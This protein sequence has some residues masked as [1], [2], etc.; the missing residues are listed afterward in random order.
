MAALFAETSAR[1]DRLD[2]AGVLLHPWADSRPP[3][4]I[5]S[6]QGL[7]VRD[8][9]G[10]ELM[11]FT[12]GYFVNQAGHGPPA[13]IEA[14]MRQLGAV[15]QVS[16]RTPTPASM[17]LA[18]A[19]VRRAPG[20]LARVLYTT[21]GSES[22]EAAI[23]MARQKTGKPGVAYLDNAFH[24]LGATALSACGLDRYRET[25]GGPLDPTFV[26][27]P[28]PHA[29]RCPEPDSCAR[30]RLAAIEAVLDRSPQVGTLLAEPIQAVGCIAPS[31]AW[32]ARLDALRRARGLLLVLDEI[33]TGL[34][35]TGRFF[36]AE[37]YGLEPDVLLVAKGLSGG[38]GSL[39]AVVATEE[40]AGDFRMATCATS[41]GNAVSCAA[42]LALVELV[43]RESL[44]SRA[45]A[46][47]RRIACAIESWALP[48]VHEVR[49]VG[50]L[51]GVDL[52]I[53]G[54][55]PM[56]RITDE[57]LARGILISGRGTFLRIQ[58]PL[59]IEPDAIDLFL[60]RLQTVLRIA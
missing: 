25:A 26:R 54:L 6:A 59:N 2:P 41:A 16:P 21:G 46:A 1:D 14:A 15:S 30:T 57:L 5:V 44:A 48:A 4:Q 33:H 58:P 38:V 37:H 29:C 31:R 12:S 11:D 39:G 43:E 53:E 32:W 23:R 42:G 55:D 22:V 60:D 19:L 34:G 24:G 40:V 45:E 20:R 50:L 56:R 13:V 8:A 52:A 47:G 10:R 9:L 3:L 36:A 51:G 7:M 49:L 17:A 35:R 18:Q 27:L 28:G